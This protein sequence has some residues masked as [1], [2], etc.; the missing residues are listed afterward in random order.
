MDEHTR[1]SIIVELNEKTIISG[2]RRKLPCAT[3]FAIADKYGVGRRE[4]GNMCNEEGIT[5][6][7]CQLGCFT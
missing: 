2:D 3:A 6:S 7:A 4:I 5:I 1:N